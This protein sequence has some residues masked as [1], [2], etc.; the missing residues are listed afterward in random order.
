VLCLCFVFG[1]S[2]RDKSPRFPTTDIKYLGSFGDCMTI[3][4][5]ARCKAWVCGCSFAGIVSSNPAGNV[6]VF[7]CECCVL[8]VR[9]PASG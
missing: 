9:G 3:P 1:N 8:T 4:V 7:P 6:D 2:G 5:A